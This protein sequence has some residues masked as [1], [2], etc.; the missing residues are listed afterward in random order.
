MKMSKYHRDMIIAFVLTAALFLHYSRLAG[1]GDLSFLVIASFVGLV[2][3]LIGAYQALREREWASMDMLASIALVFSLL[4]RE[5]PSA[6]F[7]GLMLAAARIL[8]DVTRDR[9]E[10]SIR[11]LLKLRPESAKVERDGKLIPTPLKNIQVGDIVVVD[12][13]ERIPIDGVVIA[14][15]AAVNESSLTGESLPIEKHTGSQVMSSTLVQSGNLHIR[16]TLVGEDTTLERVIR[17]VESAREEKPATQTLGEKFGKFYLISIFAASILLYLFTQNLSLVLAVVLVVC[18]DDIAVAIP[19]AYLRAIQLA[20]RSGIVVKGSKHLEALGQIKTIVFDKTGTLTTG[21]LVVAEIYPFDSRSQD[22]VLQTA[23]LASIRSSHPLSK[24]IV[25]F[26]EQSG[27]DCPLPDQADEQGGKGIIAQKNGNTILV[28]KQIFLE[29]HGVVFSPAALAAAK[30]ESTKG[31]ALSYVAKNQELFGFILA[32]DQVKENAALAIADLRLLGVEKVVM[33]TGD[34]AS[35]AERIARK[36]HI[37]EWHAE[38][39][40]EN[41]VEIIRKLELAGSVAMVGDGINDAAALSIATVGIAMGGLG[42]EGTI[43]SAQIVLMR[44]DLSTL[45]IAM[46]IAQ[47]ARR[48]SLEDF[49]IWG[50]TNVFGLA[51]VFGGVIGPAGAAAYNFLSDFLPLGNSVRVKTAYRKAR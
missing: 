24:A 12:I 30:Q 6:V 5:W 37:D 40:P 7:I 34:N 21:V 44:D 25:A 3:V 19:I 48:I 36:L 9:T 17:L 18:A 2:P 43:E 39:L 33:L 8:D 20:A 15:T 42:T 14:G 41:K 51:L 50:I 11:G 49:V 32:H 28:G 22:E 13:D 16:T 45:P 4:S 46:R 38:L 1:R 23:L 10:K 31:K 35:T 27:L 29:E 47:T 26:A